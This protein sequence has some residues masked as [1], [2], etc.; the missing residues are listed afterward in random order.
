MTQ[1]TRSPQIP[2]G[3]PTA[4]RLPPP[5]PPG[6]ARL[7][8]QP[9]D[10]EVLTARYE[11]DARTALTRSL[12]EYLEQLFIVD[13]AGGEHRLKQVV[14]VWAE[15]EDMAV[16]PSAAIYGAARGAWDSS[17][18][19]PGINPDLRIAAPDNR[20]V[21]KTCEYVQD[22]VID[23][24]AA[25]PPVR[26]ILASMI[27]K[28]LSPVEWMYGMRL[29][30]PYYHGARAT[31]EPRYAD[32]V[33]TEVQSAQRKRRAQLVVTGRIPVIRVVGLPLMVTEA[34]IATTTAPDQ[35]PAGDVPQ[36]VFGDS[37]ATTFAG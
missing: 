6:Q 35:A 8:T 21:V 32:Y 33:D 27:E 15:P 3:L 34:T 10:R 14:E 12:K 1:P 37:T 9:D 20:W 2:P 31:F 4:P 11:V 24:W 30:V 7:I 5:P 29:E 18:F 25:E 17:Q 13:G 19:T 16:L 36:G 23:L 22:L 26:S 28:N